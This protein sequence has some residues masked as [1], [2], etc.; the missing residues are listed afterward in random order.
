[1]LFLWSRGREHEFNHER[2]FFSMLRV[3]DLRG[4]VQVRFLEGCD[5]LFSTAAQRAKLFDAV[6]AFLLASFGGTQPAVDEERPGPAVTSPAA[7]GR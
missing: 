4:R 6:T 1:M 2:Q 5:H 3:P 7:R